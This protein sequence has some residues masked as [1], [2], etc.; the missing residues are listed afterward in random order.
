MGDEGF[1]LFVDASPQL[2]EELQMSGGYDLGALL[3]RIEHAVRKIDARRV[4]LASLS[5]IFARLYNRRRA[6][7]LN[8]GAPPYVLC[9]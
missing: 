6:L 8:R 1:W 3:A 2:G 7:H 4:S 9:G 5:A